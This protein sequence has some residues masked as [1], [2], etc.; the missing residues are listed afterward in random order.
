MVVVKYKE[1][2]SSEYKRESFMNPQHYIKW[3]ELHKRKLVDVRPVKG[4]VKYA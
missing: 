4:V 2:G 3:R 1:V